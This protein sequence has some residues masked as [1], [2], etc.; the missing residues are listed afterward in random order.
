MKSTSIFSILILFS[1]NGYTQSFMGYVKR[2]TPLLD[3]NNAVIEVIKRGEI[4]FV[5]SKDPKA[6][7]LHVNH[8][9]TNKDGNLPQKSIY[10]LEEA[11]E[12]GDMVFSSIKK[13]DQKDPIIKIHNSSNQDMRLSIDGKKHHINSKHT[14][15]V[16][17]KAGRHNYVVTA[18]DMHPH[19]GKETVEEFK[20]YE[21]EFYLD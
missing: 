7:T 13:S 2:E 12:S 15:E 8:V 14:L 3:S 11:V 5:F 4:V 19:F 10:I 1:L 6:T 18:A 21:W 17:L 9:R 20:M 16:S